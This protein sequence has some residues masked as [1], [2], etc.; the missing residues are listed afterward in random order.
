MSTTLLESVSGCGE[1]GE[2]VACGRNDQNVH[3]HMLRATETRD[4]GH[5]SCAGCLAQL[6]ASQQPK[7]LY[8]SCILSPE[9][10][11]R[12]NAF[13]V[14]LSCTVLVLQ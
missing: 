14:L 8:I 12:S 7:T 1:D 4:G 9:P 5:P 6:I 3:T 11:S 10:P 13:A 2:R